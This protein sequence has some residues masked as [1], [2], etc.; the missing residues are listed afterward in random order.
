M[1][2]VD[3]NLL[4]V[5][6]ELLKEP[7]TTKVGDKLGLT[8]SAISASLSRL[9]WA[10]KDDLFVR[11]GRAMVPTKKADSLAEP[12][13]EIIEKIE[14]LVEDVVFEPQKMTRSFILSA[15]DYAALKIVRPL[16]RELL[17]EAPN[18]SIR[19]DAYL[20]DTMARVRSGHIDLLIAPLVEASVVVLSSHYL[21]REHWSAVVW[22][23]NS[24]YGDSVTEQELAD[25][26]YFSYVPEGHIGWRMATEQLTD[27]LEKKMKV[28]GEFSSYL[29]LLNAM[30]STNAICFVPNRLLHHVPFSAEFRTLKIPFELESFDVGMMWS[31]TFDQNS[32]HQWL[33]KKLIECYERWE[34]NMI[35]YGDWNEYLGDEG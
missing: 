14:S 4:Y 6:R 30:S 12:V 32:E 17:D 22:S 19:N 35:K 8:Q 25:A 5:L 20:P 7:N 33:R 21:Y 11:S 34:Q 24:L 2:R 9:R 31:P 3:L 10:F 13:N 1:R 28:V 18:S 29:M 16:F 23:K 27:K 15:T 26:S